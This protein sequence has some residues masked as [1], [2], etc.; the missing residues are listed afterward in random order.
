[1]A[2]NRIKDRRR[3]AGL[4]LEQ[5]AERTG[6][7]HGYLSRIERGVR[8]RRGLTMAT[9]RRIA[10]ALDT[11]VASVLGVHE[12]ATNGSASRTVPDHGGPDAE[13]IANDPVPGGVLTTAAGVSRWRC[14]SDVL[15]RADIGANEVL[16]VDER[17]EYVEDIKPLQPVL[18]ETTGAEPRVLLRQFVPPSMLVSNSS[19][20]QRPI[21]DLDD[22]EVLIRGVVTATIRMRG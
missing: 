9:A 18:V 22:H 3:A 11:D 19:A 15:D 10:E 4:T 17:V 16:L 1:M 14:L 8:G 13:P 2:Q 12:G 5:L 6:L 20:G 21:I 7:S